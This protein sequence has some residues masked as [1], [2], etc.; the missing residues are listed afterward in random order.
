MANHLIWPEY[1]RI[2]NGQNQIA[3]YNFIDDYLYNPSK[4]V[5]A[6]AESSRNQ[7][8]YDSIDEEDIYKDLASAEFRLYEAIIL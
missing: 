3:M 6:A 8:W 1:L 2:F 5:A 4:A 7:N